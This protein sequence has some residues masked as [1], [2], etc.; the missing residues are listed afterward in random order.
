[1]KFNNKV[2]PESPDHEDEDAEEEGN[3]GDELDDMLE[4]NDAPKKD[5]DD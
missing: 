4:L 3:G 2:E 1:M 5:G